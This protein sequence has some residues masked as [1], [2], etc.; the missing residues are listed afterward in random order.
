MAKEIEV[1]GMGVVEF[2]DNMSDADIVKA[3]RANHKPAAVEA[4]SAINQIPRQLGLTA[5]YGLEGLGQAAEIVTEP[6]RQ[7]ITDPLARAMGSKRQGQPLG[8]E[9]A[10]FAD[11]LGLPK[12]EGANERV[13]GDAS[14]LVAGVT[15]GAGLAS[16]LSKTL[17]KASQLLAGKTLPTTATGT[18]RAVATSLAANPGQ[19]G[20]AAAGGG[21]AMGASREAGGDPTMQFGAGVV[22]SIAAPLAARGLATGTRAAGSAIK[23]A[24]APELVN[25]QVENQ[26]SL[27]LRGAGIDWNDI[28]ARTRQ[29]VRDEVKKAVAVGGELD[30]AALKRLIDFK[31]VGATPTRATVTL[32]P[33]QITREKNLAKVGANSMD[34]GLHSLSRIEND[35]NRAFISTLNDVGA[36]KAPDPYRAGEQLIEALNNYAEGQ[37]GNI[38]TLYQ[39]AKDSAGRSAE[40]DGYAFTQRANQLLQ[41]NLAGKLPSQIEEAL[42]RIAQGQAPLTVDHA[43]QLKTV[44]ARIQRNSRDGNEK[45][46]MGLIRQA[47]EETPLRNAPKVNPGNL[48]AVPG[49]VPPS[50]ALAGA[51][52][53]DAFNQ[54]RAANRQFMQTVEN[55][56]AL[57]AAMDGAQ[58]DN[59]LRQYVT[60]TGSGAAVNNVAAM[61][62]LLK[63]G[64]LNPA[65]LPA[66]AEQ[67]RKLPAAE[68]A[69][70][71]DGVKN[72][73]ADHLKRQALGGAADEVGNFSASA[74]NRA[75]R[76]IGD[77][78][79][80]LFFSP[81]EIK[82]LKA[83]G[84]V[85]SYTQV[86]PKGSAV[87]NSNSGALVVG[88]AMDMLSRIAPRV[89]GLHATLNGWVNGY[90]QRQAANA[91]MGLLAPRVGST[92]ADQ[93]TPGLLAVGIGEDAQHSA[94]GQN[95]RRGLLG[96]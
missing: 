92:F 95:Q 59:F 69:Q 86:Q 70:A 55:V 83:L 58:P 72:A 96:N 23:S 7:L 84:R 53:V 80:S 57:Q 29:A 20:I 28:D 81:Q 6:I 8:Q 82:Q 48:P 45:Y 18:A 22:G 3:I 25:S 43:E 32:D 54:A 4:G 9:A 27:T 17:P 44:L 42:N 78:K 40:L 19:Q 14:R 71:L 51:E 73:I 16:G 89:P 38:R 12:P 11:R 30:P 88:G 46:A 66:T 67:I 85:S 75:L 33:V 79:L 31:Q 26:I 47:L 37:K 60:G 94:P 68:G 21:L 5:R 49:T 91:A 63:G 62:D 61:T 10:Q 41:D 50:P 64:K 13:I 77:R 76:E 39:S 1:P 24:L 34:T 93:L 74:Y 35:N 15:G 36:A 52:S 56:P 90:Q 65:N 87:N 2:P